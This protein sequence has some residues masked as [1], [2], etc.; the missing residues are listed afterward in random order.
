MLSRYYQP[1]VLPKPEG[2]ALFPQSSRDATLTAFAQLGA[3]R[4]DAKRG[5]ISLVSRELQYVIAEATR[6]LSLRSDAV[7]ESADELWKG[8]TII[9][10]RDEPC[11][12]AM[13]LFTGV[14]KGNRDHLLVSDLSTD[15]R[16]SHMG[17]VTGSPFMKFYAAVPLLSVKGLVVGTF[18][19][20]D[21][22]PRDGLSDAEIAFLKDVASTIMAHL[23]AKRV[24]QQHQRAERMIRGL[25]LYVEG[26]S[27]LR[28]WWLNTG[29]K[30]DDLEV[31]EKIRRGESLTQQA[32]EEF[33]VQ[34]VPDDLATAAIE[35]MS[36]SLEQ[37]HF[38]YTHNDYRTP[39]NNAPSKPRPHFGQDDRSENTTASAMPSGAP[40]TTFTKPLGYSNSTRTRGSSTSCHESVQDTPQNVQSHSADPV[41]E[42]S[43]A[44]LQEAVLSNEVK[45]SFSRASNLIRESMAVDGA[46]FV[47][48]SIGTFGGSLTKSN[49][50]PAGPGTR[51][52]QNTLLTTSSSDEARQ[53]FVIP[54]IRPQNAC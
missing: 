45:E 24:K 17:P 42:R 5:M 25:G 36:S 4:L 23:E 7:Y 37:G 54:N 12:V 8:E 1:T 52:D 22:K 3:L 27:S 28:E 47:D 30:T 10:K 31:A 32:N 29:H 40:D 35:T 11:S 2:P 15:D 20:V 18:Y 13:D 49:I 26:K 16:F 38:T 53:R 48:A 43:G 51:N 46:L 19:V 9:R 34:D 14:V 6:T 41:D 33:G 21:D 39:M 50:R 44:R